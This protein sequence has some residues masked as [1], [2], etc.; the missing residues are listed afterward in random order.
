MY[1][2]VITALAATATGL[3]LM[4]APA[5]ADDID[6]RLRAWC[7]D[8]A[9]SPIRDRGP[10]NRTNDDGIRIRYERMPTEQEMARISSIIQGVLGQALNGTPA[11]AGQRAG[12]GSANVNGEFRG[13]IGTPWCDGYRHPGHRHGYGPFAHDYRPYGY[14]REPYGYRP[15]ADGYRAYEDEGRGYRPYGYDSNAGPR[16]STLLDD[17]GITGL[18]ETLGL[19]R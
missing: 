7:A 17:V 4:C 11:A 16:S 1:K 13:L 3:T 19:S 18:L 15:Y 8:A 12:S 6:D 9:S 10:A 5:A 14:H 2:H